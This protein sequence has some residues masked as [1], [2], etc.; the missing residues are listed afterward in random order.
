MD[1]KDVVKVLVQGKVQG[2][3][4]RQSTR[5]TARE[6]GLTGY[7][8]NLADGSVE[9][10]F[11]GERPALSLIIEFC[12]SGPPRARV[13]KVDVI[14]LSPEEIDGLDVNLGVHFEIA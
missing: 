13:D 7:V 14:W 11:V 10:V 4:F 8:R 5:Q 1:E 3:F 12:R 9:A 6:L 2:V